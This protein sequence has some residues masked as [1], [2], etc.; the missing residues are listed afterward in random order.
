V[1][2]APW[3]ATEDTLRGRVDWGMQADIAEGQLDE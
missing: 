3:P 2:R 1:R